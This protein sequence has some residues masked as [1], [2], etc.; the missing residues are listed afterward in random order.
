MIFLL[1]WTVWKK[2]LVLQQSYIG[3]IICKNIRYNL[4]LGNRLKLMLMYVDLNNKQAVIFLEVIFT[5]D[6]YEDVKQHEVFWFFPPLQLPFTYG[7]KSL[8]FHEVYMFHVH[9]YLYLCVSFLNIFISVC[10]MFIFTNIG[11]VCVPC[12]HMCIFHTLHFTL[13]YYRGQ[14]SCCLM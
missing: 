13:I 6:Q 1:T 8:I 10:V 12:L 7:V 3:Q 2:I 14:T 11:H 4:K 9:V 5:C